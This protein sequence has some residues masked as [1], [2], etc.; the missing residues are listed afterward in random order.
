M[1][2]GPQDE[3]ELSVALGLIE[4]SLTFARERAE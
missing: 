4:E 2:Y 3:E 1:I